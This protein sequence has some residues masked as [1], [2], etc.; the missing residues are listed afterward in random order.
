MSTKHAV[1]ALL[2]LSFLVAAP[3]SAQSGLRDRIQNAKAEVKERIGARK[4]ASETHKASSTA[5]RIELQQSVVKRV[6]EHT[7]KLLE[8]T[9][10]RLE[11]IMTRLESRLEKAKAEGR[12]TSASD[13]AMA[14]AKT[15]L[16][17]ARSAIAEFASLELTADKLSQNMQKLRLVA[18][19]AK[20]HLGEVRHS[21]MQAVR[22]LKPATS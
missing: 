7:G 4:E 16:R 1:S 9:A 10:D 18:A 19:D 2:A 22:A 8:A 12:E 17:E 14:E 11:G 20:E 3:V 5:R 15:H 13:S 6:A 21:L